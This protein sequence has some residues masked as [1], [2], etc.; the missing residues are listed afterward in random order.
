MDATAAAQRW[1]DTWA[2]AWPQRDAAAIAALYADTVVYRPPAFRPPDLG[3]AGVHRYLSE[4]LP[5]E[6]DIEYWFGQPIV[7]GDRA[8]SNG[9]EWWASWTEQGQELTYAGAKLPGEGPPAGLRRNDFPVAPNAACRGC[10]HPGSWWN[11]R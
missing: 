9:G 8:A 5:V 10:R 11:A 2:R 3:L 4:Q 7:S 1:A 6:E